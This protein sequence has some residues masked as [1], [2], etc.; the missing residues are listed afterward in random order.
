VAAGHSGGFGLVLGVDRE[1]KGELAKN[2]ANW[3]ITDFQQISA[4][5]VIEFFADRARAA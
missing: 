5:R 3:V 2:G 1:N 4:D